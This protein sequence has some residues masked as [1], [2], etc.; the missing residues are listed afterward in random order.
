VEMNNRHYC[1]SWE[2]MGMV[3][4]SEASDI[5]SLSKSKPGKGKEKLKCLLW[6]CFPLKG[7]KMPH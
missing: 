6:K 7:L 5:P 2:A 3:V 4:I 1:V